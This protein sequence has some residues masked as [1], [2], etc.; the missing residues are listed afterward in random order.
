MPQHNETFR[1]TDQVEGLGLRCTSA[2]VSLAGVP[3]LRKT[4]TGLTP[5]PT[6]EIDALMKEAYG[7]RVD[8][9]DVSPGLQ[10]IAEALNRGDLGRAMIAAVHLKLPELNWQGASRIAKAHNS[11]AKYDPDEPRDARGRWTASGDSGPSRPSP[12][13]I[14]TRGFSPNNMSPILVANRS[15]AGDDLAS[16][17]CNVATRQC[18]ISALD[19]KTRSYFDSCWK[20]EKACELAV[21]SSRENPNQPIGVIYPDRTVVYILNGSAIITHIS[22]TKLTRPFTGR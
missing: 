2:G 9:A 3:L 7:W 8:P 15:L 14:S 21:S 11:L 6:D 10:V 12:T 5:R 4:L 13:R 19:D 1:L 22:G 16:T 18:Q 20:A 17:V